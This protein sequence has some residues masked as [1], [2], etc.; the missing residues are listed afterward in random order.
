MDNLSNKVK[1]EVIAGTCLLLSVSDADSLIDDNEIKIIEEIVIEFFNVNTDIAH[2]IIIDCTHILEKSTDIY[3]LG[4]ILN[5]QLSYQDKIDFIC[6]TF[7][8]AFADKS[9]HY[10]EEHIIK[11][12]ATILNVEHRDLINAKIEMKKYLS[13]K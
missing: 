7:E 12:I 11:K 2:D 5:T 3:E 6:C 8:V 9:M 10:L 4:N 13:I 1:D